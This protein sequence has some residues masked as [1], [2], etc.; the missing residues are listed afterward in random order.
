MSN[1]LNR[2][3]AEALANVEPWTTAGYIHS[4][5]GAVTVAM[6]AAVGEVCEVIGQNGH[7]C[8]AE[9]IGF[10][11]D[12]VQIMPYG[13]RENLKRGDLVM[14]TRQSMRIPVG[15]Q[16]LG[17]VVDA[18][19]QPIDEGGIIED[20]VDVPIEFKTPHALTRKQIDQIFVTGQK[21]IDGLLTLGRGQRV[22]L[23]AGS[24]VGKSTLLGQIAQQ[25]DSDLNV[26]ALIGERGREVLPFIAEALGPVGMQRSVVIV[27]TADETSL[28]RVRAAETAVVISSWFRSQGKNVMLM[29]DSITRFA[30]AQRDIGLLLGEP[31]TS[32][33]YT[34]SVF[35][36]LAGLLE[37]LGNSDQGSITGVISVLVDGDDLNDPVA[38]S[39]RSILDGHIVLDRELANAG[40]FPAINVLKSASRLFKDVTDK[41]HQAD[42]LAIRQILAAYEN[43]SDM[44]QVGAYQRGV[45]TKTDLAID[46]YDEVMRL[47]RQDLNTPNDLPSTRKWMSQISQRWRGRQG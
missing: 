11:G 8:L 35:Q 14:T 29:L 37:Q 36:K 21:T 20:T 4:V 41:Q 15:Y 18:F 22:G 3:V 1:L 30:M 24:G 26:V 28:T 13:T 40:H 2:P 46:L 43:V 25:A 19:G 38:D 9:V 34:P 23:F 10:E 17:R 31:P 44:I 33:G 45:S 5:Q 6:S 39:A 47:M 27:A 32:R 42:A 12:M 7:R 16:M